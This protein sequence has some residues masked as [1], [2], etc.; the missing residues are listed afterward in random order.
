MAPLYN[1]ILGEQAPIMETLLQNI[2]R[3]ITDE[4][5]RGSGLMYRRFNS[6]CA[7]IEDLLDEAGFGDC[8]VTSGYYFKNMQFC[9]QPE[10]LYDKLR[11]E[12]G[13]A[14]L[15]EQ[16]KRYGCVFEQ[17][18]GEAERVDNCIDLKV[19]EVDLNGALREHDITQE[20]N[21]ASFL[22]S[23]SQDSHYFILVENLSLA[24]TDVLGGCLRVP[25][26]VFLRHISGGGFTQHQISDIGCLGEDC[27]KNCGHTNELQ[28]HEDRLAVQTA[29]EAGY[30]LTW[31]RLSELNQEG[32]KL[33]RKALCSCRGFE[34]SATERIVPNLERPGN[35]DDRSGYVMSRVY[36][37]HH[38]LD[39]YR[40]RG[41]GLL[42]LIHLTVRGINIV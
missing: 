21:P 16:T 30:S 10:C 42:H 22:A 26:S 8:I 39:N 28:R 20:N 37:S 40:R 27:P 34:R 31:R 11:G 24:T 17:L 29:Q 32:Y 7:I 35:E 23:T 2:D 14:L 6:M 25:P 4:R 36:R 9:A 13:A 41:I 15:A 18:R 33:E 3:L 38:I 1:V 5:G 19:L 12:I